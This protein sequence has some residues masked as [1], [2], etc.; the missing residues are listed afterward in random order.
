MDFWLYAI[1]F[2]FIALIATLVVTRLFHQRLHQ[3]LSPSR[4][5]ITELPK[6]DQ[7]QAQTIRFPT[8]GDLTLEGWWIQGQQTDRHAILT[9]GWGAN[10][11]ALLPLVPLLLEAG[12]SVMLFDVRNHGNSDEDTFS[13]MP[14][15]A[16]DIDAA[17][18][19]L[20]TQHPNGKIAL[21]GHSVGAAAT[22]LAASR[23]D[24]ISAV[25]SLSS[26]AHPADMMKRWLSEKGIPF[27]PLGWYVLGYVERVIGHQFDDIAPIKSITGIRCPLLVVHGEDDEVIPINDVYTLVSKTDEV[28]LKILEGGHDLT[29]SIVEHGDELVQ[30]LHKAVPIRPYARAHQSPE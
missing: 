9:H 12:W 8:Q 11:A 29:P 1:G 3:Q 22:L 2:L 25:V 10:R 30:F 7:V 28:L 17:I 26:F 18:A 16:E 5:P 19:W 20:K 24:D 15:F 6:L 13:S 4:I 27:F 21:L 23:R 14:R